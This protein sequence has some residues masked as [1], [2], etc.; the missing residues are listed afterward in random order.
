MH[1]NCSDFLVSQ[2]SLFLKAGHSAARPL[3]PPERQQD[4]GVLPIP[5]KEKPMNKKV[6]P[7]VSQSYSHA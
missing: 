4:L 2:A 7:L 5:L 1:A 3:S 6:F